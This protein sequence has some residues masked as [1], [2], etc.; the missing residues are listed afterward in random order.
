MLCALLSLSTKYMIA[1]IRR[2][3]VGLFMKVYSSDI[4]DWDCRH[5]EDIE[6]CSHAENFNKAGDW[7]FLLAN[8]FEA[9]SLLSALPMA[10]YRCSLRSPEEV[11]DSSLSDGNKR[12]ILKSLRTMQNAYYKMVAYVFGRV[13]DCDGRNDCRGK[14][15]LYTAALTEQW[16]V[17]TPT[18]YPFASWEAIED[19]W[20]G[21]DTL[22]DECVSVCNRR[23]E[24]KREDIWRALPAA[25][26][27]EKW[28][29]LM[30]K[31]KDF[32]LDLERNDGE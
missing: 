17:L 16:M 25:F 28:S 20:D 27:M 1:P 12:R 19:Q 18:S 7:D 11:L 23:W 29:R 10:L 13:H 22:C 8:L 14:M 9:T 3:V 21:G 15:R 2:V 26:G 5:N 6:D 24:K 31:D 30:Q 32:R 4:D